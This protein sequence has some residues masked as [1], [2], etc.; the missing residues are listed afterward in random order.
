MGSGDGPN[1]GGWLQPWEQGVSM[2]VHSTGHPDPP[3]WCSAGPG[4]PEGAAGHGGAQSQPA[5]GW[6]RGA[7]G[8]PGADGEEQED[9]GAGAPGCQW[10]R[11]APAHTGEI[12]HKEF[13]FS[14]CLCLRKDRLFLNI[15]IYIYE[16]LYN[17]QVLYFYRIFTALLRNLSLFH[18]AHIISD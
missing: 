18:L 5:A 6:D 11:P 4:G 8:H 12:Q 17:I 14:K 13:T 10:A 7:E 1:A 16:F 2:I 3:G 9:G 15:W